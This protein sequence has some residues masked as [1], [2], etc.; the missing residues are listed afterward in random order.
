[1]KVTNKVIDN[2]SVVVGS[3]VRP[4]DTF[5][6]MPTQKNL[7]MGGAAIVSQVDAYFGGY[8]EAHAKQ[9]MEFLVPKI[10]NSFVL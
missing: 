6:G 8:G 2:R 7:P 9:L 5:Y 4:N 1:M 10:T 3:D